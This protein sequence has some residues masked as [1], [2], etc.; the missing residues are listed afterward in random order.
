MQRILVKQSEL[1]EV[2]K[3]LELSNK[4]SLDTETTGLRS[5]H[6]DR[7]FSI[8]IADHEAAYYFDFQQTL[9]RNSLLNFEPVFFNTES[10]WFMHN[11]KFD[12]AMLAREGLFI[13]GTV[14]C[15]EAIGRVER[16]N[17]LRY[18]L[19]FL[20]KEIGEHKSKAVDEYIKEYSLYRIDKQTGEKIPDFT[21]VPLEIIFEYGCQD[22]IVTRK[23][24]LHQEEKIS[25]TETNGKKL[26][27]VMENER[28]LTPVLFRME[29]NGVL[30][31][32]E[33]VTAAR[34]YERARMDKA[35]EEFEEITGKEFIDSAKV[36]APVFDALGEFYP[37][38][39]K[40]N[41]SFKADSLEGMTTPIAK[42]II[43]FRD[44]Q[45]KCNTYY[46]NFLYYA[47][48]NGYIHANSRQG[49][50]GTGRLSYSDPN[51][52]NVNKEKDTSKP[53]LVRRSFIPR[54]GSFFLCPDFDQM[55]YKK[56]LEYAK[57][58]DLIEAVKS[59]LDV[60]T[61]T[62]QMMGVERD[63]AKTINFMLL[64]GGGIAKLCMALF[65]PTLPHEILLAIGRI[66]I[67]RM[68]SYPE[69]E[70]HK[71]M[72]AA[73]PQGVLEH[74]I[75]ELV[76]AYELLEKY[77]ARLPNVKS[78]IRNVQ[79]AAKDRGHIVNWLGR[80]SYF[81]PGVPTHKAPNYLIQGGCADDVK[82]AMVNLDRLLVGKKSRML[83][84]IHDE[85]LFEIVYGEE[86]LIPDIKRIM[87][88][89]YPYKYLPLTVG[90]DYATKSWADKIPYG[91]K[92]A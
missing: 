73:I 75:G 17:R 88:S 20:A 72:V 74:N 34:D 82:V 79:K 45:K 33:Y 57:Q 8:I 91:E 90:I 13:S 26:S 92:T 64:Y 42:I 18:G 41:P 10:M 47:D 86:Y 89:A 43:D 44:A 76:K 24:G 65:K 31:N 58:M 52:Q 62:A 5:Y 60:H 87:E 32:K 56:M 81:G 63:S 28:K 12:L 77:F 84:Q 53:W 6:D 37:R 19:E 51:L 27:V 11:A 85:L 2:L 29:R 1:K 49:G 66:H 35:R 46:E 21:R 15:T 25:G 48:K 16:N 55:E 3:K 70:H 9:T 22:A 68:R 78:F 59:G 50:T 40:G 23:L 38:T 30:I 83:I 14:H 80:R 39:E 54:P 67:Y 69:Y 36:L 7:L 71:K 4:Y 61:A